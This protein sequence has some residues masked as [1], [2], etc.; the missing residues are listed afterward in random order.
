MRHLKTA[1]ANAAL[2]LGSIALSLIAA[3]LAARALDGYPLLSVTLGP[4][5]TEPSPVRYSERYI[6]GLPVAQGVDRAWYALDPEPTHAAPYNLD[7]VAKSDP[8]LVRIFNQTK[9]PLS[10]EAAYEWNSN[11]IKQRVCEKTVPEHWSPDLYAFD[12]GR[13]TRFPRYRLLRKFMWPLE[14]GT[15][16]SFGLRGLEIPFKKP[17]NTIRIAFLG[18]STTLDFLAA[19]NAY[20]DF[21]GR[22]LQE[23]ARQHGLDVKFE[24]L[25]GGRFGFGAQD[26]TAMFRDEVLPLAPDIVLYYEGVN[27]F[28]PSQFVKWPSGQRPSPPTITLRQASPL[29]NYS[30]LARKALMAWDQL[31]WFSGK[32][33]PKPDLNIEDSTVQLIR[34]PHPDPHGPAIPDYLRTVVRSLDSIRTEAASHNALFVVAPFLFLAHE[35]L[36]LDLPRDFYIFKYLNDLFY[37]FK[38]SLL[39]QLID[40][41]NRVYKEYDRKFELPV[42]NLDELYP[43]DPILFVDAVHQ[44]MDGS[45]L[46]AWLIF[47]ELLPLIERE[48][49]AGRLPR[50]SQQPETHPAFPEGI[51]RHLVR[52]EDFKK[53]CR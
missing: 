7:A 50:P 47:N 29:E 21:V 14:G 35:G 24:I 53:E 4:R 52:V 20:P 2:L 49:A 46:K 18:A 42:M 40:W 13:D 3:E 48:I 6:P 27:D 10:F 22:W 17:A 45:R 5:S 37:P 36:Q 16:N 28:T 12:P 39:R 51:K 19:R 23:W 32:E 30:A 9:K 8:E 44:N 31:R 41:Q 26:I 25:N 34:D 1:A 33:A 15:I 11:W 38:Y 43:R